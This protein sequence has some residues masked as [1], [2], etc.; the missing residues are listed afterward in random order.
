VTIRDVG[1]ALIARLGA[2]VLTCV[3]VLVATASPAAAHGSAPDGTNYRS[4]VVAVVDARTGDAVDTGAVTWSV[5]GGDGL[6]QV[7]NTG[8]VD[9]VVTGYDE[10]PYLRV[11]PDGVF[12]NRNAPAT[13]LNTDR[14]ANVTVPSDVAPDDAPDWRRISN[15]DRWRWH[16]HRIHWMAPTPPPQVRDR[17]HVTQQVLAWVVPFQVGGRGLEVQ[18][19]LTYAP[20]PV[21][22]PWLLGS[23]AAMLVPVAIVLTTAGAG[24]AVRLQVVLTALVAGAGLVVAI[25][26]VIAAPAGVG[27]DLWAVTQTV[28]PL[29]VVGALAWT[30]WRPTPS[31]G[32]AGPGSTLVVAAVV[33]AFTGGVARLT[34][35]T[36]SQVI[37][38]LPA[39]AVRIVV[40]TSLTLWVT[41][42]LLAV[43]LSRRSRAVQV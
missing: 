10:E 38:A 15:E 8:A 29:G 12:E 28:V 20:P 18:G 39:P 7:R 11:G 27:T 42:V 9:V 30:V 13:Y 36:S 6:L 22:W 5:V 17:P 35:L 26:D 14:F 21:V 41:A 37:N 34:Q 32:V 3:A 19:A 1:R 40:A 4:S 33:I 2:F 25:G 16:D 43:V 23:A 24:P 31:D